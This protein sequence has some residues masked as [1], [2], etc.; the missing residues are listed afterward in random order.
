M[1]ADVSNKVL[2]DLVTKMVAAN[3]SPKTIVNYTQVVKLVVA[4]MVNEDGDQIHPRARS[5]SIPVLLFGDAVVRL[6]SL[7]GV[8]T[9]STSLRRS[10]SV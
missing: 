9:A 3:L 10:P 8:P 7:P 2:R 4:S 5:P 6:Q 1:L